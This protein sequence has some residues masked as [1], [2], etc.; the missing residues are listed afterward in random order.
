MFKF[1]VLVSLFIVSACTPA[2]TS[3]YLNIF[4]QKNFTKKSEIT[5]IKQIHLMSAALHEKD[6]VIIGKVSHVSNNLTFLVLADKT[7]KLIVNLA[8]VPPLLATKLALVNTSLQIF[9]DLD[10]NSLGSPSW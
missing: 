6:I 7:G 3:D 1:C 10:I 4:F 9:G 8:K 2:D 5:A